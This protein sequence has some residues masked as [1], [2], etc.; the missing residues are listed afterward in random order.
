MNFLFNNNSII[1]SLILFI[2]NKKHHLYNLFFS[3]L[4]SFKTNLIVFSFDDIKYIAP[5]DLYCFLFLYI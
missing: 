1:L 5:N 3:D 4:K 2:E